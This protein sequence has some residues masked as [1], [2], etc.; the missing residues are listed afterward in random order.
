MDISIGKFFDGIWFINDAVKMQL[1]HNPVVEAMIKQTI[2]TD[3]WSYK[4]CLLKILISFYLVFFLSY[5]AME[6]LA[7]FSIQ[8]PPVVVSIYLFGKTKM[9]RDI[10]LKPLLWI[11]NV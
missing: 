6:T 2:G 9:F 5:K 11:T 1:L 4:L 7:P 10:L 3:Y 8:E